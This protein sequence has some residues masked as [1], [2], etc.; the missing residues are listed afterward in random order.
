ML[1]YCAVKMMCSPM[2]GQYFDTMIEV[3][4]SR[5][6]I[7]THQNRKLFWATLRNLC[8]FFIQWKEK[9]TVTHSHTFP[10]LCYMHLYTCTCNCTKI[11]LVHWITR[12]SWD[13]LEWLHPIGF[14]ADILSTVG[15]KIAAVHSTTMPYEPNTTY[16]AETK[17]IFFTIFVPTVQRTLCSLGCKISNFSVSMFLGTLLRF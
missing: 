3:L 11:W 15:K 12:V 7:T 2:I 17:P 13:W 5:V 9:P 4:S 1:T 10:K 8:H 16:K 14:V 6:A